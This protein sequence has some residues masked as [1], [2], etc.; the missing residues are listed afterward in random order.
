[1]RFASKR[2]RKPISSQDEHLAGGWRSL[3][4][5]QYISYGKVAGVRAPSV[6]LAAAPNL[7]RWFAFVDFA[8]SIAQSALVIRWYQIGILLGSLSFLSLTSL[9]CDDH[10]RSENG[11]DWEGI[12]PAAGSRACR[13]AL[14][15]GG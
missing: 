9:R 8:D 7:V 5:R 10:G 2:P 11:A 14:K 4:P 13:P 6:A 12:V 1:M 15:V 3:A